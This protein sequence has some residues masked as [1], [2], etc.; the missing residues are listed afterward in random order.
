MCS[1]PLV[2]ACTLGHAGTRLL[3]QLRGAAKCTQADARNHRAPSWPPASSGV[4]D[5]G[6]L[7][8][9]QA[10]EAARRYDAAVAAGAPEAAVRPRFTASDLQAV[11]GR[12]HTVA[13]IDVLIHYPQARLLSLALHKCSSS[14]VLSSGMLAQLWHV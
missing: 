14:M 13:C 6:L 10:D 7:R 2:A 4:A 5:D 1:P 3:G 9:P 8:A 11:T 12:F